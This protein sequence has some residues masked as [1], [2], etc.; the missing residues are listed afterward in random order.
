MG[1]GR[2]AERRTWPALGPLSPPLPLSPT[3]D[4]LRPRSVSYLHV[5]AAG[6]QAIVVAR[7]K[8]EK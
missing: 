1:W 7:R 2:K 4:R 5:F 6:L 3:Q 8:G